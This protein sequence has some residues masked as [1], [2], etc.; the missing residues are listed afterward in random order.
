MKGKTEQ[1]YV[2]VVVRE[3]S[4]DAVAG[5]G[6][7]HSVLLVRR[8]GR[9]E[10]VHFDVQSVCHSMLDGVSV[11]DARTF[12]RRYRQTDR[13]T[14]RQTNRQRDRQRNMQTWRQTNMR[15]TNCYGINWISVMNELELF[16]QNL[17][18]NLKVQLAINQFGWHGMI[19]WAFG[20]WWQTGMWK[21]M[22]SH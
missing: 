14:D 12:T 17:M 8:L 15:Q 10:A 2:L 21:L 5:H 7:D 9:C 1:H 16:K 19:I 4:I 18:M 13:Q 20:N 3:T 6:W 22:Q 11:K